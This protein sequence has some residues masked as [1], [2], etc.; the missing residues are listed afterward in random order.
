[1][2]QSQCPDYVLIGRFSGD[3]HWPLL[4]D[5][6]GPQVGFSAAIRRIRNLSFT[7]SGGL[8]TG[9]DFQCQKWRKAD[10]CQ[11]IRVPGLRS[12]TRPASQRGK[13]AGKVQ[14]GRQLSL[15]W[16]SSR[17]LEIRPAVAEND[18]TNGDIWLMCP[19]PLNDT[20]IGRW[21]G[22]LALERWRRSD[23]TSSCE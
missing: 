18:G 11:P 5:R 19:K 23:T 10:P 21:F 2:R 7:G 3:H 13:R 4:G 17:V 22:R 1:M 14:N 20:R 16:P 8:P 15:V 12:P 9:L 6:R